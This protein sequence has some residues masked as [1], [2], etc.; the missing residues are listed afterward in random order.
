[1]AAN[2]VAVPETRTLPSSPTENVTPF[3]VLPASFGSSSSPPA[4][5]SA[6]LDTLV[7][8]GGEYGCGSA[9]SANMGKA[10]PL[11]ATPALTYTPAR[12]VA[13]SPGTVNVTGSAASAI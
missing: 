6:T 13:A 8:P 11:A 7:R 9:P 2:A 10:V 3:A 4:T 5:F 1:M 12:V